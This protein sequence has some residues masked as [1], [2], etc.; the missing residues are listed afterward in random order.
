MAAI[1]RTRRGAQGILLPRRNHA[2]SDHIDVSES[3]VRDS[4]RVETSQRF[5]CLNLTLGCASAS[6]TT[7]VQ[8]SSKTLASVFEAGGYS[9]PRRGT[10]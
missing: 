6:L 1:A 2:V 4:H 3:G 5:N 10:G 9:L 8:R 7:G